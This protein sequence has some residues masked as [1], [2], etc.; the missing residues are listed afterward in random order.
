MTLTD[1]I[2]LQIVDALPQGEII[3]HHLVIEPLGPQPFATDR[4][5]W[6]RQPHEPDKQWAAFQIY[7]NLDKENRSQVETYRLYSNLPNATKPGPWVISTSKQFRWIE[8]CNAFDMMEDQK[9][10]TELTNR[11]LRARRELADLGRDMRRKAHEAVNQLE[12]VIYETETEI[13]E[14]EVTEQQYNDETGVVEDVTVIIE[15]E[16]VRK[17]LR[18][19]LSASQITK[20]AEVGAKLEAMGLYENLAGGPTHMVGVQVGVSVVT[21]VALTERAEAILIEQKQAA[22]LTASLLQ[23]PSDVDGVS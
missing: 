13:I 7:R 3:S 17:R 4:E 15:E 16:I 9:I 18:T 22:A 5:I 8:R 20:L 12:A 2:D 6:E 1:P 23:H 14:H 19:A 21:D 11:R 10:I